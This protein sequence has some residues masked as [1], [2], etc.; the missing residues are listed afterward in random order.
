M[1]DN[2]GTSIAKATKRRCIAKKVV[3]KSYWEDYLWVKYSLTFI[4]LLWQ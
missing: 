3:N 1:P 4:L 2:T